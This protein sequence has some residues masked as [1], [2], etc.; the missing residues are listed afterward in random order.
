[1]SEEEDEEESKWYN[2]IFV[3]DLIVILLSFL[4]LGLAG[5]IMYVCYPPVLMAFQTS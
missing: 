2:N 5:L 4:F 1:M 3:I